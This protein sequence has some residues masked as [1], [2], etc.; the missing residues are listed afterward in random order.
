MKGWGGGRGN[1]QQ[2]SHQTCQETQN[3]HHALNL[4][5]DSCFLLSP[6]VNWSSHTSPYFAGHLYSL[7]LASLLRWWQHWNTKPHP[8]HY[9]WQLWK[10][11]HYKRIQ[12]THY[13]YYTYPYDVTVD[14]SCNYF[15]WTTAK[16]FFRYLRWILA[17]SWSHQQ[18]VR[19]WW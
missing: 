19:T 16:I 6:G 1:E 18:N 17:R 8:T 7:C 9:I 15:H 10:F 5:L 2:N 13:I 4:R 12:H 3:F 14:S 11:I